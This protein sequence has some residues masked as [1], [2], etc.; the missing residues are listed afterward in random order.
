MNGNTETIRVHTH[1]LDAND[2]ALSVHRDRR[3]NEKALTIYIDGKNIASYTAN[4]TTTIGD[5][6]GKMIHR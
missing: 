4:G 3:Y 2:T 6:G 5:Y 1:Y